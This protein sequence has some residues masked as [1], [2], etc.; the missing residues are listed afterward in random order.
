MSV[1]LLVRAVGGLGVRGRRTAPAAGRWAGGGSGNDDVKGAVV[2]RML[3]GARESK[4]EG[5]NS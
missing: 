3:W 2:R 1:G 5:E 4:K